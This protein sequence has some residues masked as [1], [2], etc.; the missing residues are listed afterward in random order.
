MIIPCWLFLYKIKTRVLGTKK[1][2]KVLLNN[3][4]TR[5]SFVCPWPGTRILTCWRTTAG[6]GFQEKAGSWWR[7]H[8]SPAVMTKNNLVLKRHRALLIRSYHMRG[9]LLVVVLE[10]NDRSLTRLT[11]NGKLY[12]QCKII[13]WYY[14]KI[15]GT[16]LRFFVDNKLSFRKNEKLN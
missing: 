7:T 13:L 11:A 1:Q 8:P 5:L 2:N 6:R 4:F 3:R 10:G 16:I 15:D 14:S 12:L 9:E